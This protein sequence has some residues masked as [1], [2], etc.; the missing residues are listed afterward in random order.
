MY[1]IEPLILILN[2]TIKTHNTTQIIDLIIIKTQTI[3][4]DEF[5]M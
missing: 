3:Y 1:F 5:L 2:L 4:S